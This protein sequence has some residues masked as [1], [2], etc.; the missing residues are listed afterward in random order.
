MEKDVSDVSSQMV[1]IWDLEVRTCPERVPETIF[2]KSG[3]DPI[4][5]EIIWEDKTFKNFYSE[6]KTNP[7]RSK[8]L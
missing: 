2:V 1:M 7:M 3:K 5:L 8:C 4:K 6:N